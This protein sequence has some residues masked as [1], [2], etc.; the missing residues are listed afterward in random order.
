MRSVVH[1]FRDNRDSTWLHIVVILAFCF[2]AFALPILISGL[3]SG[4]DMATDMRFAT[5]F[6]DA[7]SSG[8][9]VPNWADDNFGYGSVGIR[10]YPPLSLFL[11][12]VTQLITQDWFSAFVTNMYLWMAIGCIGMYF[13]VRELSDSK[14]GL[15]AAMIYAIVPQHLAEIFQFFMFAEF[16]AWAFLPFCFFYVTRICR[17]GTWRDTTLFAFFYSL[18]IVVHIPTTIIVSMC[19]P[20]YVLVLIDWRN[21]K[22]IVLQ[23]AS[24]LGLTL[25]ATSFRWV[26][27]VRELTWLAHNGPE[28]YNSGYYEFS[29]WLFPNIL[30]TRSMMLYVM[31]SWLF[32]I[33]IVMT[34]AL[35]IPAVLILFRRFENR[36]DIDRRVLIA[37]LVTG[38]FAFFML[39]RPSYYVWENITFLQKLQFPW[40]WL[41]V[42]SMFCV[43]S[44]S[45]ALPNLMS[46]FQ[47]FPRLV[48]Y[49]ALALVVTIVMFDLTQIIIPS[50]PYPTAKFAEIQRSIRTEEIWKGWW[51]IWAKEQAFENRE[52]VVAGDRTVHLTSWERESK[53]FVVQPGEAM[54]IS[55]KT[56]YYPLWKATVNDR[57][58]ETGMDQN[59]VMTIPIS[60]EV[61]R[62]RLRFEEPSIYAVANVVSALTWL[63]PIFILAFVYGRKYIPLLRLRP[64]GGEEYDY[65]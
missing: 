54:T 10:F 7:I 65:S 23:L 29:Q 64:V 21:W 25:L 13:F 19:L 6:Q 1:F 3:P 48:A 50:A 56:F 20:I 8:H 40:R 27:T 18:L 28:H 61:S 46:R 4:F 49:P 52:P 16:A 5:A 59:G 31:S 38:A 22:R 26:M 41:S 60:G 51:P 32:D 34:V 62:I 57:A 44:F 42:L 2:V 30:A 17:G 45:I 24:A 39:S 43:V 36:K 11:L 55:V 9:L 47:R 12:G 63:L 14:Y 58:V 37:A 15:M 33:S 53:E 35:V